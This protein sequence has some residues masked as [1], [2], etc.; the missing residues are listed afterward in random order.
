MDGYQDEVAGFLDQAAAVVDIDMRKVES[1]DKFV[2]GDELQNDLQ[3]HYVCYV[4]SCAIGSLLKKRKL[5]CDYVAGYSMGLLAAL[6]HSSALSFEDGLRLLHH[7]CTF[8]HEALEVGKYGMGVVVG[9]TAEEVG[10]LIAGNCPEVEVTDVCS[11]RVVIASGKRSDLEK[12]LAVSEMEGSLQ[13]KLLPV[14][15]P[16]HSSLLRPV[17]G[18]IRDLLKDIEIH[19]PACGIISSVH[20]KALSSVEDVREEIAG[21]VSHPIHWLNTMTK[22]LELG[23]D[24]FVEC[25]MSESLFRLARNLEGRFQFYHPRKF[26]RLFASAG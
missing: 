18:K 22:L 10:A 19:S 20:Q 25:G 1:P 14:S 16:F 6:Y 13:S 11:P 24:L 4:D 12:L 21:N 17:E 8:A 7:A 15:A 26:D 3:D 23:V 9:L 2:L 5:S